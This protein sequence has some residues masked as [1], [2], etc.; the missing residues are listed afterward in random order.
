MNRIAEEAVGRPTKR[1]RTAQVSETPSDAPSVVHLPL[2]LLRSLHLV[3]LDLI[4]EMLLCLPFESMVAFGAACGVTDDAGW[5]MLLGDSLF[6]VWTEAMV[7]DLG[8]DVGRYVR[9]VVDGNRCGRDVSLPRRCDSLED[10]YRTMVLDMTYVRDSD[11][12]GSSRRTAVVVLASAN[13]TSHQL[14]YVTLPYAEW[15][16]FEPSTNDTIGNE[17][18]YNCR[19]LRALDLSGLSSATTVG[20]SF[21]S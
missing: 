11:S 8:P 7:R 20:H 18:L 4:G 9:G 3:P 15:V 5:G 14:N 21:L 6:Y 13:R 12:T 19:E 16:S 10:L 1:P 17:F 2:S